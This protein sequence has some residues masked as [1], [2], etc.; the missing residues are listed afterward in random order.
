M[1]TFRFIAVIYEALYRSFLKVCIQNLYETFSAFK[2]I[3][4][5]WA[6]LLRLQAIDKYMETHACYSSFEG[7]KLWL[8]KLL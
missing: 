5:T 6:L 7:E 2:M 8:K 1:L 3:I 4:M